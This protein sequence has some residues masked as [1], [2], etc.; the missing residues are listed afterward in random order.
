M[1]NGES[2]EDSTK[3]LAETLSSFSCA[4]DT[5]IEAFLRNRAIEF[6]ILSKARTYLVCDADVFEEEDRFLILGYFSLSLKTLSIPD[7]ISNR[8]R[9]DLDGFNAKL[10]GEP[11][12]DVPCYLIGQ[13]GKNSAIP[14]EQQI[15]SGDELMELAL[16]AMRP[17]VEAVGGRHVM[18]ECHDKKSITGVLSA[19]WIRRSQSSIF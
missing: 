10:H 8:K 14:R 6:E 16:S 19:K 11:I 3:R 4:N 5:D 7:G 12:R 17:A 9:K 18:I 1:I 2:R 15:L 13:F